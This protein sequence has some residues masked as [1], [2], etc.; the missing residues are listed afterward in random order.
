MLWLVVG[1]CAPATQ[2]RRGAL[3]P[4]PRGD[5]LVHTQR[6]QVE[7]SGAV[8]FTD[9]D[10]DPLPSYGDPA[11]QA[12]R[13]TFLGQA[14]L[15]VGKY[16]RLGAQGFFSHASFAAPTAAGTP[17][18]NGQR[19][20]GLGPQLS[21]HFRDARWAF[22]GGFSLTLASVPWTAWQRRDGAPEL[23]N[24]PVDTVIER[25]EEV[26]RGREVHPLVTIGV[27]AT[28]I[29][30]PAF[31]AFVGLTLQS[32]L[33]N[34]GFDD[35]ERHGSTLQSDN[36]GMAPF[37]GITAR[38]PGAGVYVRAQYDYP[39]AFEQ[40]TWGGARSWGGV[41]ASVG[42]ELGPNPDA[43]LGLGL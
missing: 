27:G 42:V 29:A 2:Y 34:I 43:P 13:T 25:Y 24:E 12:A 31:E 41:M 30:H 14:R 36:V 18:M 11:L 1:A 21:F 19:V 38:A 28:W 15:R 16:L 20:W 3:V 33:T 37:V 39:L 8:A 22:G 10:Q 17:P 40:F 4:T 5:S 23:V 6:R 32:S 35:Q 9:V 26:R 7:L